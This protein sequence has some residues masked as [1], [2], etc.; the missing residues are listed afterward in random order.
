M[1]TIQPQQ[2]KDLVD[3]VIQISWKLIKVHTGNMA[4]NAKIK[5]K[6]T[7]FNDLNRLN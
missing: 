7:D 2:S 3:L 4:K 5:Y 6:G 1:L